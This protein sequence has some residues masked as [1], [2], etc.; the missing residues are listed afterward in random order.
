MQQFEAQLAW[1]RGAQPFL[2]NRYS[3]A[4]AWRFDGGLQVPASSSPLSVPLPMSDPAAVDP[5]EALVAAVSSCHM[6]FF[7]SLAARAGHVVDDYRDHAIGTMS[8]NADGRMAM[9]RIVLRPAIGFA[10]GTAPDAAGLDALHHAAHAQCYIANSIKADVIV[11]G[12][13]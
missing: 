8:S 6:L 10:A 13:A 1:Q 7:L 4:H 9:T 3:R 5:E 11:E 2:D 12:S